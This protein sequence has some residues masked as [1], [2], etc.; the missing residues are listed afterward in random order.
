[1]HNTIRCWFY[2]NTRRM[3]VSHANRNT[4]KEQNCVRIVPW[5]KQVREGVGCPGY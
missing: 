1:M 5:H 4:E 3:N 2:L